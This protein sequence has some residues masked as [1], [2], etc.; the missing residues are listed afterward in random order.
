MNNAFCEKNGINPKQPHCNTSQN[1]LEPQKVFEK[2]IAI[3]KWNDRL[4][5]IIENDGF[6]TQSPNYEKASTCLRKL[7]F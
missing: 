1:K 4:K 3:N 6:S 5:C 7:L 2:W